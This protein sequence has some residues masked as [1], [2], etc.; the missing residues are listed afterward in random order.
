MFDCWLAIGDLQ[1][2]D[3]GFWREVF[4][5]TFDQCRLCHHEHV[6]A[7]NQGVGHDGWCGRRAAMCGNVACEH[8]LIPEVA[9]DLFGLNLGAVAN[10]EPSLQTR[11]SR[12]VTVTSDNSCTFIDNV[13]FA[14]S[15]HAPYAVFRELSVPGDDDDVVCE[16]AIHVNREPAQASFPR[17]L[18]TGF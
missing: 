13:V 8:C 12:N 3:R 6:R 11:T 10:L 4:S 18:R 7:S 16:S 5:E 17:M 2:V 9:T 14:S 1:N 15:L